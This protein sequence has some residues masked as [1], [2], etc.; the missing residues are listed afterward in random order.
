MT[1]VFITLLLC[2]T[3]FER[4]YDVVLPTITMQDPVA[5]KTL[6]TPEKRR[7]FIP[8]EKEPPKITKLSRPE[9][10]SRREPKIALVMS[11]PELELNFSP[12]VTSNLKAPT[13]VLKDYEPVGN[14]SKT[15]NTVDTTINTVDTV[16]TVN[17]VNT[18]RVLNAGEVDIPPRIK[19][20]FP[21]YYPPKARGQ[22]IE[23]IVIVRALIL[24]NGLPQ[25]VWVISADP[26]GFFERPA[27]DA[28]WRWTFHPAKQ[29]GVKV[30]VLVDIPIK[31]N[32]NN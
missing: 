1:A 11:L 28:V 9:V 17:T 19:K 7:Q 12:Q 16:D 27:I 30:K 15:V 18:D 20:Y 32:L 3:S 2:F 13:P 29:D 26:E 22:R 8:K 10:K 5:V 25:K 24:P 6:N 23:G 21:P 4:S 14:V 31:F